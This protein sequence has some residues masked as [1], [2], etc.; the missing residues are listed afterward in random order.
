MTTYICR[1]CGKQLA[2]IDPKARV[3]CAHENTDPRQRVE[4]MAKRKVSA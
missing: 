3:W 1:F 2:L 4:L